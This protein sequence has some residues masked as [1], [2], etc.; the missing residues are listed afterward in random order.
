MKHV[1][2]TIAASIASG[3]GAYWVMSVAPSWH[4]WILAGLLVA[5]VV[6]VVVLNNGQRAERRK[7]EWL[8][9]AERRE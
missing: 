3:L 4:G 5:C 8:G 9:D 2:R 7:R 1:T 6:A